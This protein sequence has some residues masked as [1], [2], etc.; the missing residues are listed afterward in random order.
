MDVLKTEEGMVELG[1]TF[2]LSS[3]NE[4]FVM[5]KYRATT[6]GEKKYGRNSA[7]CDKGEEGV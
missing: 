7:V 6:R 5:K 4:R 2:P 3:D 1:C